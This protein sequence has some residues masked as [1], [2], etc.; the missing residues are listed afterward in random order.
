MT[1]QFDR[2]MRA[3]PAPLVLLTNSATNAV[4]ATAGTNGLW[5]TT[6]ISNDTYQTPGITFG[7]GMDGNVPV[8]V[9]RVQDI[10]GHAL[11]PRPMSSTLVVHST[12]PPPP[13]VTITNPANNAL[14]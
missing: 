6:S 4:Q 7:N 9:S 10:Y 3:N 12:P 2:S 11:S 1:F 13:V 8:F 5:S 14:C